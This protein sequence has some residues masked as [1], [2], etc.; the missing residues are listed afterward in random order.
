MPRGFAKRLP[1]GRQSKQRDQ[2]FRATE[3]SLRRYACRKAV[4]DLRKLKRKSKD[5]AGSLD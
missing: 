3:K 4:A 1:T 2:E 5:P